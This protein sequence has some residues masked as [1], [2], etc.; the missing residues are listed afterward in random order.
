M[1]I[2]RKL[3]LL[4]AI[5]VIG[6]GFTCFFTVYGLHDMQIIEETAQRRQGYAADLI[7]I[8]AS[9]LSTIM[10]N[11]T[12]PETMEVFSAAEK[13]IG[14]YGENAI[15]VIRRTDVRNELQAILAQ[16]QRYDKASREIINLAASD[17]QAANA[18]L[19]PLYNAELK[20]FQ[21]ALERFIA[22]RQEEAA[23]ALVE[24][25][26]VSQNT[27]WAV[28][29]LLLLVTVV[30]VA[31][32]LSL[33]RSL[34]AALT[35]NLSSLAGLRQGD[36][37]QRLPVGGKD[38]LGEIAEGINAFVDELQSI[39]RRTRDRST[40]L[41]QASA[42][43][44]A[45]STKVMDGST[46]QNEATSA[47]AAA[48]EEFSVS[49]DQV[50]DSA[51]Q[52]EEKARL[53]GALSRESGERV[54]RA[55]TEIQHIEQIVSEAST[56]MEALGQQA[57][58]ISS[59]VNV[60]KEVADQTNLLALNAAIEAARAGE[61]GRG[62]AVVADE[63][64]KLAERTS[65]SAQE[66][67]K[68]VTSVQRSTEAASGTMQTGSELVKQGVRQIEEAG[69]AMSQISDSSGSLVGAISEISATLREQ[70]SSGGEIARNTERIAQMTEDGRRAATEVATAAQQLARLADELQTEVG[71]FSV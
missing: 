60:I 36:L 13:S 51:T 22:L 58:D 20:P 57:R 21:A 53:S 2:R 27:Y 28:I 61:T 38:E 18:R 55:V 54:E 65:N 29:T 7:E 1:N 8:K 34:Q 44:S 49:I 9:A 10:L 48:V 71:R 63:V 30:N 17:A 59:I 37:R 11:P 47:V 46:R 4:S 68:M 45:A 56:Q 39:V 70:R 42:S 64:R 33:S 41:A 16:W 66:I 52:A 50:S 14:R 12:L 3:K 67:T 35:G 69:A 15:K 26:S 24:A 19:V 40:Q 5:T 31:L 43:F 62:F 32:V 25:R 6:L 23:Q